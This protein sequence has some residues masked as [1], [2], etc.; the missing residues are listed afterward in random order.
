MFEHP[1]FKYVFEGIKPE[2][3]VNAK[4]LIESSG[5]IVA[6]KTLGFDTSNYDNLVIAGRL[7][8]FDLRS[9]CA[10]TF[11]EY[12]EDYK[13]ILQEK[14]YNYFKLN[15][16]E[17]QKHID[18]T[19]AIDYNHD[20]FSASNM[21]FNYMKK[22]PGDEEPS[23]HYAYACFR[24]AIQT[25]IDDSFDKVV[26]YFYQLSR[27]EISPPSPVWFNAC[28][29][30]NYLSSCFLATIQ[31]DMTDIQHITGEVFSQV[32][33]GCGA[34]GIDMS[35]LRHSEING[36][37]SS[38]GIMNLIQ[39]VNS[40][41]RYCDQIGHRKGNAT[42]NLRSH[43]I[44]LMSFIQVVNKVG[45]RYETAHDINTSIFYSDIFIERVKAK[46]NWTLMCPAKTNWLNELHGEEFTKEYI[47]TEK[48]ITERE[49][50]YL[51]VL[52]EYKKVEN[53]GNRTLVREFRKKL[54]NANINRIQHKIV[55]AYDVMKLIVESH[56]K[57]SMPYLNSCDSIN[58][59]APQQ[60]LGYH[61]LPNL[62]QEIVLQAGIDKLGNKTIASC[63]LSSIPLRNSVKHRINRK[64]PILEAIVDAYDFQKH[65][66]L[67]MDTV[68]N[69]DNIIDQTRYALDKVN[70]DGTVTPG[71]IHLTNKR[72]RPLGIG[73]QGFA[74][75]LFELDLR[76]EADKNYVELLNDLVFA[77][78]YFN[79]VAKSV[80][81]AIEK[82]AY[83]TCE[84]SPISEGRLQPDLWREELKV[85]KMGKNHPGHKPE[86]DPS[87]W[88]QQEIKLP[89]EDS[90]K[91]TWSDLRR[92]AN[93]YKL[94]NSTIF[95]MM[96]T[97]TSSQISRNTETNEMCTSNLY[98]RKLLGGNYPWLNRFLTADLEDI[99]LWNNY[100]FNY[101][102]YNNGSVKNLDKFVASCIEYYP[103][104]DVSNMTRLEFITQKFLTMFEC[105]QKY[106]LTLSANRSM[107][108]CNST[109]QNIY[110]AHPSEN[111]LIACHLY[112][113]EIG[114]K[115]LMYYLRQDSSIKTVQFA[116]DPDF[117]IKMEELKKNGFKTT[118]K[119]AIKEKII[120]I[121]KDNYD[122][123]DPTD[124]NCVS[125]H[126]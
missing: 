79:G 65:A 5:I 99:N 18:N 28:F 47:R 46:A 82:G 74:E 53:S 115:N 36:G 26:K 86:L 7:V 60:N 6:S 117:L 12:A 125:C 91:P 90:I 17:I 31:D 20:Y 88:G 48:L 40:E 33:K 67:T 59:K 85:R 89:N 109:S 34:M 101:L 11:T 1:E 24:V 37:G 73:T 15:A 41:C 25:Y 62:C 68:E 9:K 84:G 121:I 71:I 122:V 116:L 105:S 49:V 69:V 39:V 8:I 104:F 97:A 120:E 106:M 100:T 22:I 76:I 64:L 107:Y 21:K 51:K 43:H 61:G 54:T 92:V 124:Q 3:V 58:F 10:P 19:V 110:I 72:N 87:S 30:K 32:S 52:A 114:L 93:K 55:N 42:I 2:I 95:A 35:K 14:F 108:I 123:C 80:I 119:I 16:I 83:E 126:S 23:E 78:A 63:N 94:R 77:C 102:Q 113:H 81:L 44:D 56:Q 45:D 4:K 118:E 75:M 66:S 103:D 27:M 111:T 98:S 50:E 112:S 29:Q 38:S 13:E 57:N 96:P 70:P